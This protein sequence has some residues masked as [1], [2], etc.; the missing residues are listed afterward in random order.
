MSLIPLLLPT[1]GF[2]PL[3]VRLFKTV[4]IVK[5]VRLKV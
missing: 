3:T 5:V 4:T 2:I 1:K